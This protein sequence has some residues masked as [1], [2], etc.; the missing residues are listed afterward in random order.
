MRRIAL[1]FLA[2]TLLPACTGYRTDDPILK[3][4]AAHLTDDEMKQIVAIMFT[5][6]GRVVIELHPEW[7]PTATRNFI[8]L[9][10]AGYYDG[11]TICE[12]RPQVWIRGG[13]PDSEE[14]KEGP[15]YTVALETPSAFVNR[16]RVGLY[17]H[18]MQPDE[19]TSQFF[20]MLNNAPSMN[21]GYSIFGEVI[22]GMPTV[23]RIGKIPTT[24][25]DSLPRGY[26]PLETIFINDLQLAVKR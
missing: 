4:D 7:A 26:K 19:G 22:E 1:I 15:G 9:V 20:I 16:G 13:A 25:R 10:K 6:Y 11:M 24:P 23:D 12:I 8:K 17:H 5:E 18:D 21:G 14:C 2:I 3:K